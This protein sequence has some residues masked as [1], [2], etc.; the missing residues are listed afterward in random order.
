MVK[1]V[2]IARKND[3]MIFCEVM[4]QDDNDKNLKFIRSRAHEFLKTTQN[5]KEMCTVN[6]DSQN[7]VFHYKLNDN[8][9]YLVIVDKKYPAKL[10]FCFLEELNEG[11]VEVIIFIHHK[12]LKNHFGTQSVSYYSK[13]ET[14]DR[15]NYFIK[16]GT[17]I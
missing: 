4:D 8:I 1:A 10:A 3:G 6:I 14:I 9:V 16:F 5:K 13:L 7:Y 2:I 15:A 11:F 17:I 12:E